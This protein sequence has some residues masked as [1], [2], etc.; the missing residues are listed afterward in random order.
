MRKRSWTVSQLEDSVQTSYSY[1]SVLVKLNLRPTGGNYK[2]LQK[3]IKELGLS[4][5]HFT[6]KLWNK[7]MRVGFKPK[8]PL[9]DILVENSTYQSYLLRNRL[10]KEGLKPVK[11]EECG[12][13]KTSEGGRI[14]LEL[15]HI[16]GN[17]NDNRLENLRI[18]CPNCHSLKS[19]HRGSNKHRY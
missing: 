9:K 15:D 1:R 2:Q 5:G 19:N 17:H 4:T 8:I 11:C 13:A 18:L 14:P 3:Y 10:F 6:G 16:N 12:W 7:G